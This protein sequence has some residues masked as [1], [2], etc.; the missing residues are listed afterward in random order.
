VAAKQA[1]QMVTAFHPELG[2]DLAVHRFFL[3]KVVMQS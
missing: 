3:D 1:N 2:G